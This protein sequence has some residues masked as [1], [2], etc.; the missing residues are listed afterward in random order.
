MMRPVRHR[1]LIS[2][3]GCVLSGLLLSAV[4]GYAQDLGS[5]G[6]QKPFAISG[7]L[8]ITVDGYNNV[9]GRERLDPLAWTISGSPTL[10]IYGI[11][12][13]IYVLINNQSRSLTGPYQQFGMSPTYKW[14]KVH[15][16]Y[17]NLSFSPY[18]LA[19]R[20]FLGGGI[21]LTPGKL[22]L[23]AMYGQFEKAQPA[24]SLRFVL[25]DVPPP[26][27]RF[28]RTG[29]AVKVGY[30]TADSYIDLIYFRAK[31]N[32]GS[33]RFP[34]S[35]R[36]APDENAVVGL[37]SQLTFLK[38][39]TWTTSLG[40]S[41]YTRDIRRS[42]NT[43][44]LDQAPWLRTFIVP[45]TGTQVGYAGESSLNYSSAL[46]TMQ[47]QVRQI[48]AEYQS[49]GAYFFN[50]DLREIT[51]SPSL[52]LLDGKI[53]VSGS[54]GYQQDNVSNLRPTT[55]TRQIGSANVT[56]QPSQVFSTLLSYSDYGT[57]Q[58]GTE[59]IIDTLRIQQVN[60]SLVIAPRLFFNGETVQHTLSAF[61]SYQNANDVNTVSQVRTDFNNILANLNYAYTRPKERLSIT[62]GLSAIRN[63]V[64]GYNTQSFGATVQASKG[65]DKGKVNTSLSGNYYQNFYE[66]AANG[67]TLRARASVRYRPVGTHELSLSVASTINQDKVV[68][69]RNF[70]ELFGQI[71]YG[72]SF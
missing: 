72:L 19:G 37:S 16:G 53:Q 63:F 31:D 44:V 20:L 4:A 65:F 52:V 40:I 7:A 3:I 60:Q 42:E 51:V 14:V 61:V 45:R 39:F 43:D 8:N 29:Y 26:A 1:Y 5:L 34:A 50:N 67:Y 54:Y 58:R 57:S 62:P 15:A 11:S 13:P 71:G 35:T 27:P 41:A 59:R 70:T 24:D 55:T 69:S 48:S 17:R 64:P 66:G 49:M 12:L 21:E 30:G 2:R 32:V 22:R 23:A 46:L 28:Q 36:I 33:I 10:S 6:K 25:A 38:H 56:I 68:L 18:T 9:Q 47:L